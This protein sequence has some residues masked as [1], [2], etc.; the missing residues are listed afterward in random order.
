MKL[1]INQKDL[2]IIEKAKKLF[3]AL[4]SRKQISNRDADSREQ[5]IQAY[6][7]GYKDCLEDNKTWLLLGKSHSVEEREIND[8]RIQLRTLTLLDNDIYENGIMFDQGS[9]EEY[10][11][12]KHAEWLKN[13]INEFD[14]KNRN[15]I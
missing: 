15:V 5:W 13:K 1:V 14:K 8:Y 9:M 2:P 4:S 11:I 6:S 3:H 7:L 10:P 12:K